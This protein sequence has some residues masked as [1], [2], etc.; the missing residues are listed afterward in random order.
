MQRDGNPPE[1]REVK[2][3]INELLRVPITFEKIRSTRDEESKTMET[4]RVGTTVILN[5]HL[6]CILRPHNTF[7][8]NT[9]KRCSS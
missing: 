7:R 6:T 4:W 1:K 8:G 9:I 3:S 5:R 2:M